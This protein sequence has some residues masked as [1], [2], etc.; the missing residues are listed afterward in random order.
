MNIV[1][2][3]LRF[4]MCCLRDLPVSES[5]SLG[6]NGGF[7]VSTGTYA[8]NWVYFPERVT[9]P[10]IAEE[11][12]KFFSERG[13]EAMWPLYDSGGEVLESCG[14]IY[15]EDL[16][17]M[18][19][20]PRVKDSDSAVSVER[21]RTLEGA[22]DW[23]ETAGRGFG[24]DGTVEGYRKFAEALSEHEGVSLYLAKYEGECAGTFLTTNGTEATGVYYF[25]VVPELRR[26]GIARAMMDEV[27]RL[28]CG[29]R[30]V[31]QATPIGEKFYRSYGFEELF[32]IRLYRIPM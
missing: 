10:E 6:E 11:S 4:F 22:A 14:L 19:L 5:L 25:A 15:D 24:D 12:V 26:K 20:T 7:C 17:A 1:W 28:T 29:K 27:C 16:T 21:V 13:E 8:E 18:T 23:A 32:K 31:L 2:E 3:N 9:S 30:I